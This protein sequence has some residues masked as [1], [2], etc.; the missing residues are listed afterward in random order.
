M[1]GSV[2]AA[3]TDS[4]GWLGLMTVTVLV[5]LAVLLAWVTILAYGSI[6]L[7]LPVVVASI[8]IALIIPAWA[9]FGLDGDEE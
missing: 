6:G 3:R 9:V 7:F 5:L 8:A 4:P 2:P 1:A